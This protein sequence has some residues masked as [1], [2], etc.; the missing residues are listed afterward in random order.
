MGLLFSD[1]KYAED[2]DFVYSF[3]VL[4]LR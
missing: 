2:L 3:S 1:I 4:H